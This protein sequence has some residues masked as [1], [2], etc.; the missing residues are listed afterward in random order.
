MFRSVGAILPLVACLA[1]AQGR[2]D[3]GNPSAKEQL[4]IELINRARANPAAEGTWL[5]NTSDPVLRAPYSQFG[6]DLALM[7]TEFQAIVSS[8]PLAP[9]AQLTQ[10]ARGHSAWMLANDTQAHNQTNP[11]STPTQ[12]MIA[13]GY[14]PVATSENVFASSK[15]VI[16]AH[17]G[18]QV[19]WGT[20]GTGGMQAGRG[21]RV[22]IHNAAYREI[23]V[24]NLEG[25][26]ANVGP[27]LVTQNFGAPSSGATFGTGVAYYDLNGNDFYDMGEGIAGL[28]VEVDGANLACVTA[29]GGGWALPIPGNAATRNVRF[30]GLGIDQAVP[31]LVPANSNAKADLKLAYQGPQ[32]KSSNRSG[33]GS[34]HA[35]RFTRVTGATAYRWSRWQLSKAKPENAE[36]SS[37]IRAS[38]T[39]SYPVLNTRVHNQGEASFQLIN[40]TADSQSIELKP[41]FYGGSSPTLHFASRIARSTASEQCKVQEDGSEAWVDVDVQPG[42]ATESSFTNRSVS[43]SA[44][45]GKLFRIRFLLDF[46]SGSYFPFEGDDF[47]W[48]IDAIRFS[49]CSRARNF[50]RETLATNSGNF[51]PNAERYLMQVIPLISGQPFRGAYRFWN[52]RPHSGLPMPHWPS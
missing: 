16:H 14:N 38:T 35:F 25:D 30:S 4:F 52:P 37:G 39:G 6:V 44:F 33:L 3:F 42:D 23:G 15:G 1:D 26:N 11:P 46:P 13:A 12:R 8:P 5:A 21:H 43:L 49:D 50:T 41:L 22:N 31:L 20:G 29:D 10:A 28:Q 17:A 32:I 48:F 19:D 40:S 34:P 47:G 45:S 27:E 9:N 7:Q 24:G 36:A 51:T 2:Y 18:F